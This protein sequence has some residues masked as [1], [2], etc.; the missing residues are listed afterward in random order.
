M[1]IAGLCDSDVAPDC[2]KNFKTKA[3]IVRVIDGD[4]VVLVFYDMH[5]IIKK[6]VARLKGIDCAE[7]RQ[8][9]HLGRQARNYLINISTDIEEVDIDD[10]R[11]SKEMQKDIDQNRKILWCIFD[12]LDKYGRALVELYTFEEQ[13]GCFAKSINSMMVNAQH[14]IIYNGGKKADVASTW[15]RTKSP[16][17]NDLES[18]ASTVPH[19]MQHQQ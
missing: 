5:N 2:L 10:M 12:G 4:T 7:M 1:D 15:S 14:A 9:P 6:K 3:K 18:F 19:W 17:G 13:C 11:T 16:E 8:F